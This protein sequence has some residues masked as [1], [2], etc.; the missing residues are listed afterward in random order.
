MVETEVDSAVAE[1][2][3]EVEIEMADALK[4]TKLLAV[5]VVRN[6]NFLSDRPE[7]DRFSAAP[8]L[9]NKTAAVNDRTDLAEIDEKDQ[10]DLVLKTDKCKCMMQL[11]P[12]VEQNAKCLSNRC[13]AKMF[14]AI[15]VFIKKAA[16]IPEN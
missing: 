14:S 3:A 11:V 4:C 12:N 8:V 16:K 5:N 15:T 6:A 9:K 1:A 13:Q 7:T 2:L 10:I